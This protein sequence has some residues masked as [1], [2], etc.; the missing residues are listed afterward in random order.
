M[1]HPD[2]SSLR[3]ALKEA[4]R[5]LEIPGKE[6]RKEAIERLGA[7][8]NDFYTCGR[9]NFWGIVTGSVILVGLLWLAIAT[10]TG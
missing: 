2:D 10:S 5:P 1:P 3:T 6:N 9:D 4:F 7:A 8:W